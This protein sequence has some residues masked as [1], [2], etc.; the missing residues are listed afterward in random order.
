LSIVVAL[1]TMMMM[2]SVLW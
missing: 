1:T 2:S